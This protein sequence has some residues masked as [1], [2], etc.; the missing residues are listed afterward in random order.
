MYDF[1]IWIVFKNGEVAQVLADDHRGRKNSKE[2]D[3]ALDRVIRAVNR[4]PRKR[5]LLTLSDAHFALDPREVVAV[6]ATE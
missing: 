5:R 4:Y 2:C 1:Q 6:Y 3:M